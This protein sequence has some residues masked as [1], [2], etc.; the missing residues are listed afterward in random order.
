MDGER[1]KERKNKVY[2]H[3]H[4]IR[5]CAL[6]L[7]LVLLPFPENHLPFF[8]ICIKVDAYVSP[9]CVCCCFCSLTYIHLLHEAKVPHRIKHALE[10][11]PYCSLSLS[12]SL[13]LF[14]CLEFVCYV[15]RQH[16]AAI[17]KTHDR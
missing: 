8:L 11:T 5:Q 6:L 2:T 9:A 12:L 16:T 1:G 4:A 10:A 14:F 17:T 3:T 13:A 15:F 7:L